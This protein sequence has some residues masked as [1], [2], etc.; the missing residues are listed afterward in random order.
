ML[1]TIAVQGG[2]VMQVQKHSPTVLNAL[3]IHWED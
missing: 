1:E 3:H 2:V